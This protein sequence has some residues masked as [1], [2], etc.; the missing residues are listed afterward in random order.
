MSWPLW[1]PPRHRCHACCGG[2][3]CVEAYAPA[4]RMLTPATCA[5][6]ATLARA[7]GLSF[8]PSASCSLSNLTCTRASL[9]KYSQVLGFP[10]NRL[11]CVMFYAVRTLLCISPRA[12]CFFPSRLRTRS[13]W[14]LS[15]RVVG[16]VVAGDCTVGC[17]DLAGLY[18]AGNRCTPCAPR[19]K[20]PGVQLAQLWGFDPGSMRVYPT[21][22]T[23]H[24]YVSK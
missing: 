23:R 19:A 4:P 2:M 18:S 12:V 22:T 6:G 21:Y 17:V 20:T 5:A 16:C 3:S 7:A 15:S 24:M 1:W 8:P 14:S 9:S 10:V 13:R 11:R